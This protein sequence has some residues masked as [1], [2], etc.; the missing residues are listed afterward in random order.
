MK[1]TSIL[2]TLVLTFAMVSCDGLVG[3]SIPAP[4]P[5]RSPGYEWPAPLGDVLEFRTV[6]NADVHPEVMKAAEA[7]ESRYS[8][9]KVTFALADLNEDGRDEV[10]IKC[11]IH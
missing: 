1:L 9:D 6:A 4:W 7:L 8:P 10:L 3:H 2:G 11:R 5:P